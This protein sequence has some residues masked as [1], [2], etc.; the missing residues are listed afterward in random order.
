M[1]YRRLTA[2]IIFLL[3]CSS[4]LAQPAANPLVIEGVRTG[5]EA[6]YR[7]DSIYYLPFDVPAGVTKINIERE[8]VVEPQ[9][10]AG[11]STAIFDPRGTGFQSNGFRGW[12][13]FRTDPI[14]ITGD[15]ATTTRK[16]L[17]GPIQPGR[18][19]IAQHYTW[20]SAVADHVRYKY[21]ITFSFDGPKPPDAFPTP[22]YNPGVIKDKPGWYKADFHTHTTYSDGKGTLE[23][24]I[25]SHVNAGFDIVAA[26]DHNSPW[27]HYDFPQVAAKYPNTLLLA[28]EE[29]STV[30]GHM[31]S[32]GAEPGVWFDPRMVPGDGRLPVLIE[33]VRAS[34]GVLSA[35]HPASNG[36]LGWGFKPEECG[37]LMA[38]E[39]CNGW[40]NDADRKA[41]DMWDGLLKSGMRVTAV[42]GSDCH[43]VFKNYGSYN[44]VW[45]ENLSREAVTDSV[46]RGRVFI[47]GGKTGPQAYIS[48]QD[49]V[50]LPGDTIHIGDSESVP[51][52]ARIIGAKGM[53]LRIIWL[54]GETKIPLDSTFAR[55]SYSVP[56]TASLDKSYVRLEV[57][58]ATGNLAALTNPIY[59]ERAATTPDQAE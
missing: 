9:G 24:M 34:G 43:S 1:K 54:D 16:F 11:L 49:S 28:G 39:V 21:I 47:S 52:R 58:N 2:L 32:I 23:E 4:L 46:R 8:V 36:A 37:T 51:L 15:R 26:T 42:C 22:G 12:Q 7:M 19:H 14:V 31:N 45:A 30:T 18:W 20:K 10:R 56:V 3:A 55:V 38:M 17:W 27:A 5:Q 13:E 57:L 48:V 33:A 6:A 25:A 53:A 29:I 59:I 40:F 44:W 35:N 50:A 41:T